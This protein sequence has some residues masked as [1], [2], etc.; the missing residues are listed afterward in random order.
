MVETSFFQCL[1]GTS[2]TKVKNGIRYEYY[3]SS[4]FN[5]KFFLNR[6]ARLKKMSGNGRAENKKSP[7]VAELFS[8]DFKWC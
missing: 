6:P 7:A 3:A 8:I 1:P 5:V 2:Q 4:I